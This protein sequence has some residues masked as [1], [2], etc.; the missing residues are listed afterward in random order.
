MKKKKKE[1]NRERE[2]LLDSHEVE[3]T[4]ASPVLSWAVKYFIHFFFPREKKHSEEK[5]VRR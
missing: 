3:F 5:Q 4:A 1:Q 2:N